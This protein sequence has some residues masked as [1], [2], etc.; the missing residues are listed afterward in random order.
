VRGKSDLLDTLHAAVLGDLEPVGGANPEDW[1]AM[2]G[3]LARAFRASLLRHPNVVALFATRPVNA[4]AAMVPIERA[5]AALEQARFPPE[6]IGK[7]IVCVGVYSIGHVLGE[8][9]GGQSQ[10][11]SSPGQPREAE[12]EFGLEAMLDGLARYAGKR[13]GR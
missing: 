1:R 5:R 11:P 2:L 8:V 3:G 6:D 13:K 4:P 12:F 7:A 10:H 9:L